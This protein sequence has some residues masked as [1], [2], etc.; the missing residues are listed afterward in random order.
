[1]QARG[2]DGFSMV[3]TVAC[4]AMVSVTYGM[5]RYAYGL[6]LPS[7]RQAFDLSTFQLSLIASFNTAVYLLATIV[8]SAS[9]IYFRPKTL[10]VAAG[11]ITTC[12]LLITGLATNIGLAAG[13]IILAGVG[14]GILSP[15]MFEAIEAWLSGRW[16][17]RAIAAVNAG[18]APGLILT[19]LSAYWLQ[20]SWQQVWIAMAGIGLAVTLWHAWLLPDHRITE[21]RAQP[22]LK[23]RPALFLRTDC[24]PLYLSLFVYGLLLSTYLTFAVDLILSTGGVAFPADRLF[25]VLL[26]LAGLLAM[27]TGKAV[28]RFGVRGLLALSMPLCGLSYAMLAAAPGNQTVI[29]LSAI[30]F[31]ISSIAPGNGF[32]VWGISLFRDRPSAGT[33]AVFTVLSLATIAGPILVGS[34]SGRI[35][36]LSVFYI[37]AVL[38]VLTIP[39]FPRRLF[40]TDDAAGGAAQIS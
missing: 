33:G 17:A 12:G 36:L 14:G 7:I 40:N 11:L 16:K 13:G 9:A 4:V 19:G 31:G 15:A 6:F 28:T 34:F 3:F 18:A 23:L 30:L 5:G 27:F 25:W 37:V 29:L 39:L 35:D 20:T 21:L 38:P 2:S 26:G 10:I 32:L 8:A 22:K 24:V 1:M